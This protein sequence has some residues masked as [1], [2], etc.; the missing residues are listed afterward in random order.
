VP[1]PKSKAT[2]TTSAGPAKQLNKGNKLKHAF[3]VS[4]ESVTLGYFY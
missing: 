1:Q 3:A 4:G 2:P